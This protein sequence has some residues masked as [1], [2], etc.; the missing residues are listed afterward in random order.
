MHIECQG[1]GS[2]TVILEAG[3]GGGGQGAWL[4][5]LPKIAPTTRVCTYDRA[6]LGSS[7]QRAGNPKTSVGDMAGELWRLLAAAH[8]DGP[9]VLVGHS[10]GGMIIRVVAHDHPDAVRGL[11]LVDSASGHQFEGDWLK[12]DNEWFDGGPVDRERSAKELAAVTSLGSIPLVV[13]TQGELNGGFEVDWSHFQ[14]ELAALSSNSLHV[15]A[16]KSPHEINVHA[17]DLVVEATNEVVGAVRTSSR[18]PVCGAALTSVGAECLAST[19]TAQLAAWDTLRE[20]VKPKAGKLPRGTYRAELTAEASKAIT[21][22]AAGFK[23][24]EF[25]WVLG[26][27][28]WSLSVIEDG[29][30]PD[31]V[32]DIYEASTDHDVVFR[33]PIDWKIPRTSGVNQLTWAVDAK[34]TLT[35]RQVD[36]ERREPAFGVPWVLVAGA[37]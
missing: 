7:R 8:V 20:A 37:G 9:Y 19:M 27:G 11:V 16:A 13:L 25:T 14:D 23:L 5:V 34:G 21:G 17:P 26:D 28:H 36:A 18:L 6:G 24:Q 35:F 30:G 1:E 31:Q 10:F 15:V 29:T 32:A 2:P 33:I 12:N 3:L 4:D 22:D